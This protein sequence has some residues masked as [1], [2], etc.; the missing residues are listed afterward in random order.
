MVFVCKICFW[1]IYT[2][3]NGNRRW[4]N[5]S[6]RKIKTM[7]GTQ[8]KMATHSAL[9]MRMR[10]FA[11]VFSYIK[12]ISWRIP[13][14]SVKFEQLVFNYNVY[15]ILFNSIYKWFWWCNNNKNTKLAIIVSPSRERFSNL[16]KIYRHKKIT[17]KKF[18]QI[19][20]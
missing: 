9:C 15:E 7:I 18:I 10:I 6:F 11:D 17:Q 14:L 13:Y 20:S 4:N 16:M 19:Y 12:L 3:E 8:W 5:K 2:N 1:E